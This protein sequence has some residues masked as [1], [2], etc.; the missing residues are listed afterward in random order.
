MP[1]CGGFNGALMVGE[2]EIDACH[3]VRKPYEN[4]GW[5]FLK[6]NRIKRVPFAVDRGN[7]KGVTIELKSNDAFCLASLN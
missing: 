6:Q 7:I 3:T 2:K 4:F 1:Y 5:L